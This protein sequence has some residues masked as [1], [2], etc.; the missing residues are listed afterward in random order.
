MSSFG[1]FRKLNKEKVSEICSRYQAGESTVQLSRVFGTTRGS[2]A[3]LLRARDI[4]LRGRSGHF[5][6]LNP[7]SANEI[8][9]RYEKGESSTSLAKVFDV[10]GPSIRSLLK[11]RNIKIRTN[12]ESHI[13]CSLN[14]T[15]FDTITEESAYWIGFLM[16]DGCV[17]NVN[18][19]QLGL[20]TRDRDHVVRFRSFLGSSHKISNRNN[21]LGAG[22]TVS[23]S[24]LVSVL[25]QYG[26]VP[27]KSLTAQVIGLQD[28]RHFWRGVVDGDGSL[29]LPTPK[30]SSHLL[31]LC[32]SF[33][34]MSQFAEFVKV[35]LDID[36]SVRKH[37]TIFEVGPGQAKSFKIV[38]LLYSDCAIALPR[39]LEHAQIF[40]RSAKYH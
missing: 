39:K 22:L 37:K 30:R 17:T 9:R 34:L 21:G 11:R 19:I 8:C 7:E 31:R 38:S 5:K 25:A 2:I 14:E 24:H 29:M 28:N 18:Q 12:R 16:A 35:H 36:T 23:S 26:V 33:F 1:H 20:A 15:V 27:R 13:R 6:K 10:A 3:G 40:M 4:P 32:G